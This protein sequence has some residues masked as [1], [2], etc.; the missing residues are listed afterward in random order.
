MSVEDTVP[1]LDGERLKAVRSLTAAPKGHGIGLKNISER[2][3]TAFPGYEMT[4][5]SAPGAGTSVVL[6]IPKR[7]AGESLV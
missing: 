6:R 5:D 3:A 7:K 2:L 4:I 1:G